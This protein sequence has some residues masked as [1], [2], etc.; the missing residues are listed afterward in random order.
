MK[1]HEYQKV[2]EMLGRAPNL[3]EL[4]MFSV[5]WSE[6]CSYKHSKRALRQ[7]PTTGPRVLQG[8]GENAGVVDIDNGQA[9]V[10]KIESHNHPSAI[11]PYQ[12]AAT[13]VGG[14][15]RDV[16]AMGARPVALL[17]SLRFGGLQ[18]AHQRY[19]FSG[20]V[21]GIAGYGNC[22]GIP[23]VGGE[24]YFNESYD[25]NC[26]VNAMCIG[27]I[28]HDRLAK[29]KA[30]GI[31][32]RVLL[33]GARTGRD[34]IH[35]ATFA[36]EELSEQSAKK[37]PAV[38]VGDPFMEKLL[39]EA[40]LELI[41]EKAIL[42]MQDLGAAGLTS[43]SSEMAYRAGTGVEI[44]VAKVPRREPNMTAYEVMLSESQERM[45]LIVEPN[46]VDYVVAVCNKWGL[47]ATDIGQVTSDKM[48]R[49]MDGEVVAG[50]VPADALAALG[51]LYSP[52]AC[53][54][55]WQNQVQTLDLTKIECTE[56][57]N[58]VLLKLLASPNIASKE[59]VYR[60]YDHMVRGDTV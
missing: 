19:L 17:N 49:I 60:Q 30:T 31:G 46:K 18:S 42:G 4:G 5:M 34:G 1:E 58:G 21:A 20:A 51:P 24:V 43:S 3:V 8:P 23:T 47:T 36:S 37:R 13:G 14:I 10:F 41:E 53:L 44:D 50:E 6:H 26:L 29:G 45:L 33:I 2:I 52:E 59:W 22:L 48:L 28:K 9:V 54:P 27:L 35:G 57:N 16:F 38:Q 7:F 12:G 56:D 32:N 25:G 40:C 11:E 55:P 39:L 15:V